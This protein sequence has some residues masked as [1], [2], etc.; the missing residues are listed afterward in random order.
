MVLYLLTV[1]QD[2]MTVEV[3]CHPRYL[4]HYPVFEIKVDIFLGSL[5]VVLMSIFYCDVANFFSVY[6]GMFE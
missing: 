6:L 2:H 4:D 1:T 5:L 3:E